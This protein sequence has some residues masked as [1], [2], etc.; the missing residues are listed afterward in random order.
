MRLRGVHDQNAEQGSAPATAVRGCR[1]SSAAMTAER[2]GP[3]ALRLLPWRGQRVV[4]VEQDRDG[5]G[6]LGRPLDLV[7]KKALHAR[8]ADTALAQA[9]V[10]YAA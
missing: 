3:A 10:V 2:S 7:A 9:Q 8:L 6:V 5:R 4:A 1:P